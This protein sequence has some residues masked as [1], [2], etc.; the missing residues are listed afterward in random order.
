MTPSPGTAKY[1]PLRHLVGPNAAALLRPSPTV[2]KILFARLESLTPQDVQAL[3]S[4]V[5]P[6]TIRALGKLFPEIMP[7]MQQATAVRQKPPQGPAPVPGGAPTAAMPSA[8][9][10]P[11]EGGR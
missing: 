11:M 3:N 8:P 10:M 7:I 6:V 2:R 1:P 9:A 5:T 4:I